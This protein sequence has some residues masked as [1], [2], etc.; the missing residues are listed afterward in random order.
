[1]PVFA[2]N[3]RVLE[4]ASEA[5]RGTY[6]SNPLWSR[7]ADRQL[8]S[9]HPLGGSW[10]GESGATG[11]VNDR[12]QVFSGE[13]TEIHDGLYVCDGSVVRG[14]LGVN[15]LLTISAIS[16]RA[17]ELLASDK[18]WAIDYDSR[19]ASP[20]VG[21]WGGQIGRRR[22]GASAGGRSPPCPGRICDFKIG[23]AYAS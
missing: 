22:P 6:V 13:G 17:M 5:V 3:D 10:M 9:V 7:A 4:Q 12:C 8:I 16:E 21:R 2:R 15:P 11:V 14:S 20:S 23:N 1:M 19:K 18:G